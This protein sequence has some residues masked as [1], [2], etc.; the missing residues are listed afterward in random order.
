MTSENK[1]SPDCHS[2]NY[3]SFWEK[4]GT[5]TQESVC[6]ILSS[7]QD[8]DMNDIS[9]DIWKDI[10][11]LLRKNSKCPHLKEY[12]SRFLI[13][14]YSDYYKRKEKWLILEIGDS[15]YIEWANTVVPKKEYAGNIKYRYV[16]MLQISGNYFCLT[17][18]KNT[19]IYTPLV[20]VDDNKRLFFLRRQDGSYDL[21]DKGYMQVFELWALSYSLNLDASTIRLYLTEDRKIFIDYDGFEFSHVQQQGEEYPYGTQI[22]THTFHTTLH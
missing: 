1:H 20:P 16:R 17:F 21:L 9:A 4:E 13:R 6:H 8:I 15:I 11:S 3:C 22:N 12:L 5:G 2:P 14:V 7:F 10:C 18:I 19:Y